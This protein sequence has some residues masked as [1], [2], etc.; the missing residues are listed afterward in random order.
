ML[1][2]AEE[3]KDVDPFATGWQAPPPPADLPEGEEPPKVSTL[4][5]TAVELNGSHDSIPLYRCCHQPR[6]S[7][8][9]RL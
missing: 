5:P 8:L 4:V 2:V 3:E 1:R 6:N 7:Q 9:W